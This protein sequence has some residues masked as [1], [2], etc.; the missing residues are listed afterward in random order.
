MYWGENELIKSWRS[1]RKS[2]KTRLQGMPGWT[3]AVGPTNGPKFDYWFLLA[4]GKAIKVPL[5]AQFQVYAIDVRG[6][7]STEI[8]CAK[9]YVLFT[10]QNIMENFT[11]ILAL[12]IFLNSSQTHRC[13]LKCHVLM[14]VQRNARNG[15]DRFNKHFIERVLIGW[16]DQYAAITL[17]YQ[18]CKGTWPSSADFSDRA[19]Q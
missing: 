16:Y 19:G 4:C 15:Q 12:L 1:V 7:Y 5:S 10:K 17:K 13:Q 8:I 9:T 11:K 18:T 14:A 2:E 3:S 6:W